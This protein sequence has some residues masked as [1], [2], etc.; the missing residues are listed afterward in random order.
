MKVSSD[1]FCEQIQ[2]DR[3]KRVGTCSMLER[4]IMQAEA[5]AVYAY[6]REHDRRSTRSP[7]PPGETRYDEKMLGIMPGTTI[8]L[9]VA[10]VL[11]VKRSSSSY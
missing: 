10:D 5:K 6:E 1:L 4:H 7:V 9:L 2:K 8:P 11:L 3:E